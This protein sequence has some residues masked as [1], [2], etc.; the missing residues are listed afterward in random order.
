MQLKTLTDFVLIGALWG[1]SYVFLRFTA[2]IVEPIVMAESRLLIG[3]IGIFVIAMCKPQWRT[4]LIPAASNLKRIT[5][6]AS[7]HSVIPFALFSYAMQHLSAGLGAILNSTSPIWTAVIGALWLKDRLDASRICGLVLGF[8]G[9]I[10]LMWDKADFSIGGLGLPIL[11]SLGVTLSYGI[12]TNYIKLYGNGLHPIGL[13]FASLSIGSVMLAIPA[14]VYLPTEA[15]SMRT[16]IS[17]IGL[18]I[19]STSIAYILYYR[20]IEQAGPTI[21]ITVTFIVPIFSVFWGG[22]FLGERP[23]LAMLLGGSVI[24]IGTALAVG[25]WPVMK[26]FARKLKSS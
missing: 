16:W 14:Y 19:G 26:D 13:A 9:I 18:G 23:T 24:V 7:L 11:A 5:I 1:L 25:F 2:G 15:L 21:A 12:A 10:F 17:I 3:A 4:H 22:I 6:I 8:L 20:L